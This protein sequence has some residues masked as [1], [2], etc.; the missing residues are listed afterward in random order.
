MTKIDHPVVWRQFDPDDKPEAPTLPIIPALLRGVTGRCPVCGRGHAFNG[1][2]AV[3]PEC[4]A[5]GALL[6]DALVDDAPPYFTVVLVALLVVPLI[7]TWERLGSPPDWRVAALFLP[8]AVALAMALLR[9]VK[10]ATLGA[11][12]AFGL[13]KQP[14][15]PD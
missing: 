15:R 10:G 14:D 12:V 4:R 8:L 1:Y 3:A 2:L 7:L 5:C 9:P 6:G 11:V 13:M